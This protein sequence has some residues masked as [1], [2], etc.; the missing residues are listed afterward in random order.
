MAALDGTTFLTGANAGFIA[1]LYTRFRRDP[2]AV[3]DSWRRFFADLDDDESAVLAELR[4]PS[5]VNPAGTLIDGQPSRFQ[6]QV[7][8]HARIIARSV[9]SPPR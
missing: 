3:D 1:E 5:W 6:G 7:T 9:D 2:S 4:G 8:G